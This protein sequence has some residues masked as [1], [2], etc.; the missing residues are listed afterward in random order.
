M[1]RRVLVIDIKAVQTVVLQQSDSRLHKI[2]ACL[3]VDND[4]VERG[5]VSPTSDREE[6]L[7]MSI[8]LLEFIDGFEVAIKV[9]PDIIPGV[10]GVVYI[11]VRP[12]VG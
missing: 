7:E 5:R 4:R 1:V 2:K 3:G 10:A 6:D 8:L 11:F 9:V 12:N